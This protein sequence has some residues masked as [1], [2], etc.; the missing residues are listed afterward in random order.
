MFQL[1][2]RRAGLGCLSTGPTVVSTPVEP[3]AADHVI[4]L[5]RRR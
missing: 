5:L 3:R 1:A 4:D 2:P